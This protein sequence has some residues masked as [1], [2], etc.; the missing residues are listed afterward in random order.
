[1]GGPEPPTHPSRVRASSELS[2]PADAGLMGG[3]VKPGHDGEE[4]ANPH[5]E[6]PHFGGP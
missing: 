2:S 4:V 5:E 6:T 1:M 3:R